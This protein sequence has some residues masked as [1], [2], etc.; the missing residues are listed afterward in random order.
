MSARHP[1]DHGWLSGRDEPNP[2]P[3]K[4]F[5]DLELLSGAFRDLT[6]LMFGHRPVRFVFDARNLPAFFQRAH[7][8]PK[9]HD[10]AGR[11]IFVRWRQVE[12]PLGD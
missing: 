4:N 2:V 8:S 7:R 9:N 11:R 10:G 12:R 1:N 5:A 3:E 6:H